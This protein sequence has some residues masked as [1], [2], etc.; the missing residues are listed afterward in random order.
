MEKY[1]NK[2][3]FLTRKMALYVGLLALLVFALSMVSSVS[4]QEPEFISVK[5][6]QSTNLIDWNDIDGTQATGFIEELNNSVTYHYLNVK[7]AATNVTLQ[8]GYYGFTLR[9]FPPG[10]FDY[11]EAKGIDENA[12]PGT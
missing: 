12:A 6:E 8:T 4:A 11:W 1:E 3:L 10:F 9:T 5:L 2:E 7:Y